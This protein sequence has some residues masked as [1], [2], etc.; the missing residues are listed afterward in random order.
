MR[1]KVIPSATPSSNFTAW[2][3]LAD[4]AL[5]VGSAPTGKSFIGFCI[6]HTAGATDYYFA[7][8]KAGTANYV[9]TS[10]AVSSSAYADLSF[11][12]NGS[13]AYFK[14]YTWAGTEPAIGSAV[15]TDIPAVQLGSYMSIIN[16]AGSTSY[17]IYVDFVELSY[18]G[19]TATPRFRGRSGITNF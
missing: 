14:A 19:A 16:A 12:Y 8:I 2:V 9:D 6:N 1:F 10:L 5:G 15:S 3:G 17:S 13:N 18:L 11:F 7:T 4:I